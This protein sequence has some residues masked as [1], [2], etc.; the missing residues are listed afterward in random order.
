MPITNFVS[1]ARLSFITSPKKESPHINKLRPS[2]K[3]ID[4]LPSPPVIPPP[5]PGINL[6]QKA[7]SN[8]TTGSTT[9]CSEFPRQAANENSKEK[10]II[11]FM[12]LL[13]DKSEIENNLRLIILINTIDY[14]PH[15]ELFVLVTNLSHAAE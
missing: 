7:E 6:S 8:S 3:S 11:F 12:V 13:L 9:F 10:I 1:F 2:F 4:I 14:I 5:N 15:F